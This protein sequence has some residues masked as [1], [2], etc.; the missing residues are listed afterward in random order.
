MKT[1]LVA[2]KAH[3]FSS[4]KAKA[5]YTGYIMFKKD[6]V[7]VTADCN[8]A[9]GKGGARRHIEVLLFFIENMNIKEEALLPSDKTVADQLQSGMFLLKEMLLLNLCHTLRFIRQYMERH[10][11]NSS[12]CS[13]YSTY[14]VTLKLVKHLHFL[15]GWW[16]T[17]VKVTPSVV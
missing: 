9:A 6:G 5:I 1:Q 14:S 10:F 16:M 13:T 11:D 8:C 12:T 2:V 4:L 7:V 15:T 17:T 3:C